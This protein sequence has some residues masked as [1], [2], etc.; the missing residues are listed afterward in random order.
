MV[1]FKQAQVQLELANRAIG[2]LNLLF[3]ITSFRLLH[4]VMHTVLVQV[5]RRDIEVQQKKVWETEIRQLEAEG[6]CA[7]GRKVKD[8]FEYES[9]KFQSA[10]IPTLSETLAK[11]RKEDSV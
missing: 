3:Q 6:V 11:L 5:L 10:Y 1:K 7:D 8:R 9:W 4:I 2:V